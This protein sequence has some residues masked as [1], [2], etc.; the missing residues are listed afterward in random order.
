[1]RRLVV[2]ILCWM[3]WKNVFASLAPPD[4][5]G[6]KRRL[7]RLEDKQFS[8]G[9]NT[10]RKLLLLVSKM[11]SA[12][13][14]QIEKG[15]QKLEL[16]GQLA[17][18]SSKYDDLSQKYSNIEK[19]LKIKDLDLPWNSYS[20]YVET[21]SSPYVEIPRYTESMKSPGSYEMY[22][23]EPKQQNQNYT[24][25]NEKLNWQ[26]AIAALSIKHDDLSKKLSNIEKLLNNQNLN[27]EIPSSSYVEIPLPKEP[28]KN[29]ASFDFF[30]ELERKMGFVTIREK[31]YY[32]ETRKES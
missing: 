23:S 27:S 20:P 31:Q 6:L 19:Q 21:P 14:E 24:E 8:D 12:F 13:Y 7:D 22:Q 9:V 10:D 32:I 4:T 3:S 28:S 16:E 17:T 25:N 29:A 30:F 15:E 11:G 18:L 1:M 26:D 2:L 5:Y